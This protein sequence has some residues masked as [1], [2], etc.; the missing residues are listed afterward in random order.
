MGSFRGSLPLKDCLENAN[1][2]T[3][4]SLTSLPQAGPRASSSLRGCGL[5]VGL[6][7]APRQ[8]ACKQPGL[9]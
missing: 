2:D 5:A 3:R 1:T 6:Q 4:V 9:L 8:L 7:E